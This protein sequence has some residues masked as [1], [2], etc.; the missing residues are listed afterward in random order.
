MT[1]IRARRG[2]VI[3]AT[4]DLRKTGC[5]RPCDGYVVEPDTAIDCEK[6]I[7]VGKDIE[8]NGN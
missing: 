1:P 5:K 3:H 8:A 2:R 7:A 6:C 4:W